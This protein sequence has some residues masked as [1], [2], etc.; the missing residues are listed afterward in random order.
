MELYN[1]V[2]YLHRLNNRYSS[3]GRSINTSANRN[4]RYQQEMTLLPGQRNVIV[5]SLGT[6]N[7]M[8]TA[9]DKDGKTV[10]SPLANPFMKA[11]ELALHQ[12][13]GGW[14][15]RGERSIAVHFTV[16]ATI[17]QCRNWLP[18]EVGA[19][20]WFDLDNVA[21]SIYVPFYANVTDLPSTY[22]TCGRETGFS[23]EAAWWAFNR[24]GTI[25]AK[26]WGDMSKVVKAAWEPMQADFIEEHND[27]EKRA[28]Q[29]LNEGKR[30][31][32]IKMLTD[33]S[34][35]CGNAAVNKAW[36]TGDYIWTNFDGQW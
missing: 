31:E 17:L 28:L 10:M 16:Y 15:A 3:T 23:R 25:A 13:N 29:L 5:H 26:R 19:L 27:I 35:R 32:A 7:P 8:V 22:K 11:D 2:N 6:L 33:F 14:H 4:K 34:N 20:C 1:K 36:K 30:D 12:I 18:D 21:S 24:L 9:T